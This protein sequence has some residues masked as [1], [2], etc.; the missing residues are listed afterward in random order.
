MKYSAEVG[1]VS[2]VYEPSLIK[3]DTQTHVL[4]GYLKRVSLFLQNKQAK[5]METMI[6]CVG[7]DQQQFNR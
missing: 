1:S 5:N 4:R 2:K 3:R 7:K 6:H